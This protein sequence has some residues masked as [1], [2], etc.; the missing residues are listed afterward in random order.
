MFIYNTLLRPNL[1]IKGM[2]KINVVQKAYFHTLAKSKNNIK[3]RNRIRS[4]SCFYIAFYY[5]NTPFSVNTFLFKAL[6]PCFFKHLST[7]PFYKNNNLF[8]SISSSLCS[9]GIKHISRRKFIDVVIYIVQRYIYF[10]FL[11]IIHVKKTLG[12]DNVGIAKKTIVKDDYKNTINKLSSNGYRINKD[13]F[14]ILTNKQYYIEDNIRL[15]LHNLHKE[16]ALFLDY[17]NQDNYSIINENY[18]KISEIVSYNSEFLHNDSILEIAK[19]LL[20]VDEFY[21]AGSTDRRGIMY[22]SNSSLSMKGNELARGLIMFSKGEI[23]NK[24]RLRDLKI[25]TANAFGLSKM[26]KNAKID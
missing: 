19:L 21:L 26:S 14:T 4:N 6:K 24:K 8:L 15:P 16:T 17:F 5:K 11:N 25:Y 9:T 1:I 10:E 7:K 13:V 23:L 18:D 12:M 2:K 20:N 22:T 3:F